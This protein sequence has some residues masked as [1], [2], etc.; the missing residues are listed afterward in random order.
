[1]RILPCCDSDSLV[2]CD[3]R[4]HETREYDTVVVS[5]SSLH[6]GRAAMVGIASLILVESVMGHAL[7]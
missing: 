6:L 2:R 7:F 5:S 3:E 4:R 1:M